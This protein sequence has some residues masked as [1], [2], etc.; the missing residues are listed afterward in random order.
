MFQ[1]SE[2][3][4]RRVAERGEDWEGQGGELRWERAGS[5]DEGSAGMAG[6]WMGL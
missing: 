4:L 2:E 5:P 1:C 6:G 3:R